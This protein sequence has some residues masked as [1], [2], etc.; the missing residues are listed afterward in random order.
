MHVPKPSDTGPVSHKQSQAQELDDDRGTGF[1]TRKGKQGFDSSIPWGMQTARSRSRGRRLPPPLTAHTPMQPRSGI[2]RPVLPL[3]GAPCVPRGSHAGAMPPGEVH[4]VNS[5]ADIHVR[6]RAPGPD[7]LG[8]L[9]AGTDPLRAGVIH[10]FIHSF[11][12]Q[13]LIEN[14][15]RARHWNDRET[16]NACVYNAPKGSVPSEQGGWWV[17]LPYPALLGM[18]AAGE[19]QR[20]G[21]CG[22]PLPSWVWGGLQS[23]TLKAGGKRVGPPKQTSSAS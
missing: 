18:E 13:M 15:P 17:A 6:P 2:A 1:Q 23:L 12:Q 3:G 7:L 10:S 16:Q 14:L 21:S 8:S 5:P 9:T 20:E 22:A 19:A 11:I 4:S